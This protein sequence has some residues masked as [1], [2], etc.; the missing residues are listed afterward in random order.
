M[1][2]KLVL[3]VL[4]LFA[5]F[6]SFA[7]QQQPGS[8]APATE[9]WQKLRIEKNDSGN[10]VL[11]WSIPVDAQAD[12]FLVQ[13]SDNGRNFQAV[14]HITV[15]PG[16]RPDFRYE[17]ARFKGTAWYR[18]ISIDAQGNVSYSAVVSTKEEAVAR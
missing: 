11:Q 5:S 9:A 4:L 17:D 14:G 2:S 18:I 3:S 8:A 6:F 15:Q 7:Q 13:R 12:R 10:N 1:D 16:S